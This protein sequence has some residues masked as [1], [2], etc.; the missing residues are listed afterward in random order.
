MSRAEKT[1]AT[2]IPGADHE[3][4]SLL[5]EKG[6][7]KAL[8]NIANHQIETTE[9]SSE[10]DIGFSRSSK[11]KKH[12]G[13]YFSPNEISPYY[14]GSEENIKVD[15]ET[16]IQDF[17]ANLDGEFRIVGEDE[18]A[19]TYKIVMSCD[20]GIILKGETGFEEREVN[21]IRYKK[22]EEGNTLKVKRDG[23]L[24]NYG[25]IERGAG[26]DGSVRQ[27]VEFIESVYRKLIKPQICEPETSG[28]RLQSY[29]EADARRDLKILDHAFENL[30]DS[31]V[32]SLV[33]FEEK[34]EA[35]IDCQD[36]PFNDMNGKSTNGVKGRD[37]AHRIAH[38]FNRLN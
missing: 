26:K 31:T 19:R 3:F 38:K 16:S 11:T 25:K 15:I 8:R 13:S 5:E 6:K 17:Y 9:F 2:L 1:Y 18:R 37:A 23:Q 35:R 27:H 7:D 36:H 21:E 12:S 30:K 14:D 24:E 29:G 33:E 20:D 34:K 28:I 4:V 10:Y 22:G 32:K